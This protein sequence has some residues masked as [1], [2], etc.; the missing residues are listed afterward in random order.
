MSRDAFLPPA[1]SV[2]WGRHFGAYAAAVALL[3]II[4]AASP[5][6][7]PDSGPE[8]RPFAG[9]FLQE[10]IGGYIVRQG[11]KSRF[12]DA[13]YAQELEHDEALVGFQW[14]ES[15]YFPLVYPPFYYLLVS[16]LS[17]LPFHAAAV[18]WAALMS[19]AYAAAWM[20]FV[21]SVCPDR[22]RRA[23]LSELACLLPA[24]L[25]YMPLI[26]SFT[27]SQKGGLLLLILMGT[28]YLFSTKRPYLA[29]VVFGL[30]AFKPQFALPIAFFML[31]K[32]QGRFVL[33]GI[34]T[35]LVLVC[36]C[37][38]LGTG[39]C[40][41]YFEFSS[42]AGEYLH[43][44]G[45]DL[46]KSHAWSGFFALLLGETSWLLHPATI[47]ASAATL[48]TVA[49]ALRGPLEPESLRFRRQFSACI[50]ATVLLSPHL[51]TYDLTV[52]LLPL[53]FLAVEANE[54]RTLPWGLGWIGLLLFCLAGLSPGLAA[55][56]GV[57]LTVP[58]MF[59]MLCTL[60]LAKQPAFLPQN[61]RSMVASA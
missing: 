24:S 47:A 22:E 58:L 3:L 48:G 2:S 29:G 53:G 10:W 51:Y 6:F 28:F 4:F 14:R 7:R 52:L 30:I 54:H 57:Q 18:V 45:Y 44:A 50:V 12:Y 15:E 61:R 43:N 35:G 56:T 46:T 60:G 40:R 26:E 42:R 37:A 23:R 21:S 13:S 39:V 1:H 5:N 59:A 20:L 33:G 31:W 49:L 34:T 16:P 36:L 19:T 9:D 32:R 11:D 25:L 8:A 41:Q 17:L 27:S 55:A 38:A